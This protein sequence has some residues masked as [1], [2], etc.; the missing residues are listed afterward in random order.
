[1]KLINTIIM[2]TIGAAFT[3]ACLIGIY[4]A[5]NWAARHYAFIAHI[6]PII[7][8]LLVLQFAAWTFRSGF[9]LLRRDEKRFDPEALRGSAVY[10]AISLFLFLLPAHKLHSLLMGAD[11][12]SLWHWNSVFYE[13]SRLPLA[14]GLLLLVFFMLVINSALVLTSS[15]I[16]VARNLGWGLPGIWQ[17]V[18]VDAPDFDPNG[19][20]TH[21]IRQHIASLRTEIE[22][23]KQQNKD[24]AAAGKTVAL[25]YETLI[26]TEAALR[27]D[28]FR[29][30][31]EIE[32]L[33]KIRTDQNAELDE[34]RKSIADSK[35]EC[36]QF[37][38]KI[39]RLKQ[40]SVDKSEHSAVTDPDDAIQALMALDPANSPYK[41][42]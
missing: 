18:N 40:A 5:A 16:M 24:A 8:G 7:T 13:L 9:H 34:A 25:K 41:E 36:A 1:M 31:T 37:R 21:D 29:A 3:Y 4:E 30:L 28:H 32:R 22:T 2:G 33:Q 6:K 10:C 39:A 26:K 38:E 35:Q 17:E 19:K 20:A 12:V 15:Y 42:E 11:T 27:Q 23:L 14:G